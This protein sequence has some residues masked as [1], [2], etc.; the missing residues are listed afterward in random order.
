MLAFITHVE[1][2]HWKMSV[3]NERIMYYIEGSVGVRTKEVHCA[4]MKFSN[5]A[6]AQWRNVKWPFLREE[7]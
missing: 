3:S 2:T 6:L 1:W 4:G 5:N 7:L